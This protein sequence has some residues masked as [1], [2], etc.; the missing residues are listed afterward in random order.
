MMRFLRCYYRTVGLEVNGLRSVQPFRY[1][2]FLGIITLSE[3]VVQY[4]C[5]SQII[6][7]GNCFPLVASR[8]HMT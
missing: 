4:M 2:A 8:K 1:T 5:M 6:L 7:C 3:G